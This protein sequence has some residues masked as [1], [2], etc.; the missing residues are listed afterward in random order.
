VF[1]LSFLKQ[2]NIWLN[3]RGYFP[4]EFLCKVLMNFKKWI[5]INE[6]ITDYFNNI[7]FTYNLYD[8]FQANALIIKNYSG[9]PF[10]KKNKDLIEFLIITYS[11]RIFLSRIFLL[12]KEKDV[13]KG[14]LR[15]AE[16]W[17][18]INV[19]KWKE[20][21]I[22]LSKKVDLTEESR[23]RIIN[24]FKRNFYKKILDKN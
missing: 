24:I 9:T 3:E 2:K 14:A 10:W 21:P 5:L 1:S 20:N 23:Q 19:P 15:F 4:L 8:I 11:T 18:N 7:Y 22:L 16:N 17:L 12:Y 13:R 6:K